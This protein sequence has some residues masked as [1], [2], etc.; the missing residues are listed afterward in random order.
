MP[1]KINMVRPKPTVKG[2]VLEG[3]EINTKSKSGKFE[4]TMKKGLGRGAYK[5]GGC[6]QI[7]GWGK[8]RKR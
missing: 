1:K 2:K 5:D 6:A 7:K 8:A 4:R 3:K